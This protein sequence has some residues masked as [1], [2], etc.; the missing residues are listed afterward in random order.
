MDDAFA[1]LI[2]SDVTF[3]VTMA[4][5]CSLPLFLLVA[6]VGDSSLSVARKRTMKFLET[7]GEVMPE[8]LRGLI[9]GAIGYFGGFIFLMLMAY[10]MN[11][12]GSLM[13]PKLLKAT[14]YP[15]GNAKTTWFAVNFDAWKAFEGRYQSAAALEDSAFDWW[16]KKR[17]LG[18]PT[19]RAFRVAAAAS[20]ILLVAG[21]VDVSSRSRRR[22]GILLLAVA[23]ACLSI[24][25][26]IWADK[27]AHFMTRL[28]RA[29]NQLETPA[30]LPG[31]ISAIM[32]GFGEAR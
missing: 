11:A 27:Q 17:E 15:G 26:L 13:L 12:S 9:S 30:S 28:W 23:V 14:G 16:E 24:F 18:K 10:L 7:W 31:D 29:N 4:M 20:V 19:V 5:V 25:P 32:E 6:A 22:R 21:L 3:Y 1:D 2:L 8:S